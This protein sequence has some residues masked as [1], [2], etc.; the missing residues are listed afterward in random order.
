MFAMHLMLFVLPE[1]NLHLAVRQHLQAFD[2]FR[3]DVR[4]DCYHVASDASFFERANW[5]KP[6]LDGGVTDYEHRV[7]VARPAL[8]DEWLTDAP[9]AGYEPVTFSASPAGYCS[10]QTLR[11]GSDAGATLFVAFPGSV[12]AGHFA[13]APTLQVFDFH[14]QDSRTPLLNV[15]SLFDA[16]LVSVLG[17][18]DNLTRCEASVPFSDLIAHYEFDLSPAG[19]VVYWKTTL[20]PLSPPGLQAMTWEQHALTLE[21][22]DGVEVVTETII[23]VDNPNA[24]SERTLHHYRLSNLVFDPTLT[25]ADATVAVETRNAF[26]TTHFATGTARHCRYDVN[27]ERVSETETYNVSTPPAP[28][29]ARAAPQA[30]RGGLLAPLVLLATFASSLGAWRL[31]RSRR[32]RGSI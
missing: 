1:A 17:E 13:W 12:Q 14:I 19:T 22:I 28:Q 3:V 31:C 2:R 10:R 27:G 25:P 15:G 29:V 32:A 16:G 26:V 6:P 9:T 20:N 4:H 21:V 11:G 23:V 5:R 24:L 8:L 18:S 30:S 7:T